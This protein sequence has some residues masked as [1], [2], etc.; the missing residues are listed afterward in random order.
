MIARYR[1]GLIQIRQSA[2][3]ITQALWTTL[4]VTLSY[5]GILCLIEFKH[6]I[7]ENRCSWNYWDDF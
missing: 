4:L 2:R 7:E 5:F 3:T 6:I 1:Y